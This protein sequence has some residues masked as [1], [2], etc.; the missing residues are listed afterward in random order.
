MRRLVSMIMILGTSA[1]TLTVAEVPFNGK[2]GRALQQAVATYA[3]PVRMADRSGLNFTMCDEFSGVQIEVKS[4]QLPHGYVW[5]TFVPSAWWSEAT[6][7]YGE[8]VGNDVYNLLPLTEDVDTRRGDLT[9]GYVTTPLFDGLLWSVGRSEIYGIETD[10]YSPPEALRGELAR[11]FFYMSMIYPAGVWT[12]RG[13]M[14]MTSAAYPGLTEYAVQLLL[15]WHREH[16]PSA[17]EEAKNKRGEELQGNRN[18]FVDYPE[19]AEYLWGTHKGESFI[20][21][22]EPQP[23]RSAYALRTDRV[24]LCSPEIPADA[25]WTVDGLA[26]TSASIPA[27]DLGAGSHKLEYRVRSTGE[28]GMVMIKIEDR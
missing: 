12:P 13:Y 17:M 2:S 24:D 6:E 26:V 19:L 4:G 3:R 16:A 10:L 1:S 7:K 27:I 11:A 9:P 28:R 22:G 23:L 18:P 5:S 15:G 8:A 20:I 25:E 14:V 21:E